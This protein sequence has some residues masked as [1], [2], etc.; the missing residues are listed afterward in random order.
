[1]VG[2]QS[3]IYYVPVVF[4]VVHRADGT[5]KIDS[6]KIKCQ[7]RALNE[8]FNGIPHG[9]NGY[10]NP[11]AN[12]R[13]EFFLAT[14]KPDGSGTT[15][16]EYVQND[17][18]FNTFWN[19]GSTIDSI[20]TKNLNWDPTK[21]LN[22]Y[23]GQI[24]NQGYT[25]WPWIGSPYNCAGS[26]FDGVRLDY[27]RV[28]RP[29]QV[30]NIGRVAVHEVGHYLGLHHNST[31]NGCP[32]PHSACNSR[33]D[34]VCDTPPDQG[35]CLCAVHYCDTWAV[36]PNNMMHGCRDDACWNEFTFQQAARMRCT[37]VNARPALYQLSPIDDATI[38]VTVTQ[39][40][41]G[42]TSKIRFD[43]TWQ[44][45]QATTG[46]DSLKLWIEGSSGT[47]PPSSCPNGATVRVASAAS[48]GTT[49][50]VIWEGNCVP[51]I[52]RYVLKSQNGSTITQSFCRYYVVTGC[53]SCG[54]GCHPPCELE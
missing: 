51:G 37:L 6:T 30:G 42:S 26:Y 3:R 54:G 8:D 15:G 38:Q 31:C 4:H 10:F 19:L 35:D 21:Y 12:V 46:P 44:T 50:H 45:P 41:T 9:I 32:T 28:G 52:W 18:W 48:G 17:T 27:R 5:G 13:I 25:N 23:V 2:T 11:S 53:I 49:H 29:A 24:P 14:K 20:V 36:Q 39:F 22:F 40:C 16:F 34:R 33:G 47:C 43:A 7:I 1:V